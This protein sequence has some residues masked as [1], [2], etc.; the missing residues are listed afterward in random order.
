MR[1]TT[2][3]HS[4][5]AG[6]LQPLL[7]RHCQDASRSYLSD[8]MRAS[9]RYLKRHNAA[10]ADL[11]A[12]VSNLALNI[13]MNP[14]KLHDPLVMQAVLDT[15]PTFDFGNPPSGMQLLGALNAA[16]GKYFE[17]LVVDRLNKG[18]RVGNLQLPDGYRALLAESQI[19]PGWDVRIIDE[20]GSIA[21]YLQLKATDS[22]SYVKAALELYPDVTIL[23]TDEV[24][25]QVVGTQAILD[26]DIKEED[27]QSTVRNA[28]LDSSNEDGF[29]ATIEWNP[30]MPLSL[31]VLSE[32]YQI[33]RHGKR[34]SMVCE[35]LLHRSARSFIAGSIGAWLFAVGGV[36]ISI[37]AVIVTSVIYNN[38]VGLFR[39]EQLLRQANLHF[40]SF[41][42]QQ[43]NR[44][45][46][47]KEI[48]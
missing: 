39:A 11:A 21:D 23:T 20:T 32:G 41:R 45:L 19:Q 4:Y 48:K 17:Y 10:I 30:M 37:P 12:E 31:I 5:D 2:D 38:V 13:K 29:N 1:R 15:N 6:L 3:R 46:S 25:N 8:F 47:V 43:Q 36:V 18:E 14:L 27:L 33:M 26:S 42:L 9:T 16:K 7:Q 34:F 44:M 24:G 35:S 28:M 22:L 40:L